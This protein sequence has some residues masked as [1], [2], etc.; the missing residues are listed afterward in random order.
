MCR[1]MCKRILFALGS[2]LAAMVESKKEKERARIK[3][4]CIQG[5]GLFFLLFLPAKL[6][7][8]LSPHKEPLS[9]SRR[10]I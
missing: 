9:T 5:G 1:Y 7:V 10:G 3:A 4:H 2:E 6:P 8:Q